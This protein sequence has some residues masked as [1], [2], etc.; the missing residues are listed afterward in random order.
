MAAKRS[1]PGVEIHFDK[2]PHAIRSTG[3]TVACPGCGLKRDKEFALRVP[4]CSACGIEY[5][6]RVT[7]PAP[8]APL[9]VELDTGAVKALFL[10]AQ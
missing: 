9:R 8:V 1:R 2:M 4:V 5:K 3:P 10:E 7:E 6:E